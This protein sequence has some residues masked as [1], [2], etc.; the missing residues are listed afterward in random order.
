MG[1]AML[2]AIIKIA[3]TSE[4]KGSR[5]YALMAKKSV[6]DK[7]K[8]IFERLSREELEHKAAFE[9]ILRYEI[10]SSNEVGISESEIKLLDTLAKT[11]VFHKMITG[12]DT[13][14][15]TPEEA[16]ALGILAEKDAILLYQ[17]IYNQAGSQIIKDMMSR[18]LE[19][20]KMHLV[21][22]RDNMEELERQV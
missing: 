13:S 14:I 3:I 10:E 15:E 6:N 22:L 8:S 20:E 4:E 21:E 19:E 5:F 2:E 9:K 17:G 1:N 11:G 16:L 7:I 18:L 12:E